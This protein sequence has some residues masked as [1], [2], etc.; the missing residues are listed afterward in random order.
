MKMIQKIKFLLLP[1][2]I[3]LG[4]MLYLLITGEVES[5]EIRQEVVRFHV[6]ANSD[7]KEDQAV[8]IKVRDR[9]FSTIEELFADCEDGEQ[10][11][12]VACANKA[13]LEQ[14]GDRIL[15]ELGREEQVSVTVGE[16]FFPTK[17]YGEL[18]FPAGNYQAVSVSI[19]EGK[20]E[21][22]WCVLFPALCIAPAVSDEESREEMTLAVGEDGTKLLQ[23]EDQI[24]KIK[25]Q[26][27][28]W[29]E[30]LREK[31]TNS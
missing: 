7:S 24:S 31:F 8:K 22:F 30:L 20:G 5:E 26:L 12:E 28:E 18:F 19:G 17:N 3:F 11:L 16:R 9:L 15:R 21:N 4:M 1:L 13:L 23:K 6:V 2:M 27:V 29:F 25:F 14:E 10:A